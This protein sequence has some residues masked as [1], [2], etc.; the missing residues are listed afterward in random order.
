[1]NAG[2]RD[3]PWEVKQ[4]SRGLG[5]VGWEKEAGR[6]KKART[7]EGEMQERANAQKPQAAI[8]TDCKTQGEGVVY[9]LW[10]QIKLREGRA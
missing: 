2:R 1:M 10:K 3:F 5:S 6:G 9:P 4:G 7:D 8:G